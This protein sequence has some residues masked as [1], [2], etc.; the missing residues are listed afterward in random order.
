[1]LS[2]DTNAIVASNLTVALAMLITNGWG[3]A[4]KEHKHPDPKIMVGE[5][6]E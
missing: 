6:F 5:W 2:K 3:V 1:M 4:D